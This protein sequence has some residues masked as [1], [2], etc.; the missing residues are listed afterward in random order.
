MTAANGRAH[1][2]GDSIDT[3][4]LAPVESYKSVPPEEGC[5]LCLKNLDADFA[6]RVREGDVFVAGINLGVGSSREQAPLFLKMLGIR[7]VVAK[8][9][10]RIFYRNAM[11]LGLPVLVCPEA[12][13]INDGDQVR[14]DPVR[15]TVEDVTTGETFA[16]E[17]IPEH[18][19][20]MI[21]D[22]GLLAHLKKKLKKSA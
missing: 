18:L 10:A 15:G 9:F 6:G 19:M 16:C 1:V 14:V 5:R 12:D 3:D 11:N 17:P 20:E 2:F 7:A 21:T 4:M 8:S 22:G 13:K